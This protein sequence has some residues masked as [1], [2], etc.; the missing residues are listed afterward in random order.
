[1]PPFE[2]QAL[3]LSVQDYRESSLLVRLMTEESGSVGAMAKGA[4]RAKSQ[5]AGVLQPY[6]LVSARLWKR[7]S[8]GGG[9]ATIQ[10]ADLLYRPSFARIG[11]KCDA[12][13]RIAWAGV[14]AEVLTLTHENDPHGRELF[15][16]A[17]DFFHGLGETEHP[18]SFA[19][20]GY[21]ALLAALGYLPDPAFSGDA[22]EAGGGEL[23]VVFGRL[24][25]ASEIPER[26]RFSLSRD[27]LEVLRRIIRPR[28]GA[29]EIFLISRRVGRT[30][31]RLAVALFEA[32]LEHR[33]RSARFLEDMALT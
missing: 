17:R 32:H 28:E 30:L 2:T 11:A 23:D 29:D 21:F 26:N 10:N 5:L 4:R 7:T 33:L 24:A 15:A 13:A 25:P 8:A 1:M 19:V 27:E 9:L 12:L 20:A 16:L 22:R 3:V 6:C 14:F 18:G 31:A